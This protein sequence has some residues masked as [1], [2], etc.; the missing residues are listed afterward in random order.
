MLHITNGA[1][2]AS[3]PTSVHRNKLVIAL[4]LAL[5][6][7]CAASVAGFSADCTAV[8][9]SVLRLHVLANSDSEEDQALKL[10]V[11]D[12]VLAAGSDLFDGSTTVEN[13][14]A[15]LEAQSAQLE[16]AAAAVIAENG[17][18][19]PISITFA[20]EYF[21]TRSYGDVTL[22]AGNYDALK[23]VI[24]E[25]AGQNWWCIMF[26]PL[27]LPAAQ[28]SAAADAYFDGEAYQVVE[29]SPKYEPRFKIVEWFEN[30]RAS[31]R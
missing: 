7:S 27:C 2:G 4:A 25:G 29:H 16:A 31:K 28:D 11:R 21:S 3:R 20:K 13:A 6:L 17:C 22:P 9:S 30:W 15:R 14:Q 12:A 5:V 1:P 10:Q 23:V 19:Y 26:P 8:R 18:D 24:G